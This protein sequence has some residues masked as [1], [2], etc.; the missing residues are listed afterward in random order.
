[1]R[2]I[3]LVAFWATA[4]CGDVVHKL[5][6][7]PVGTPHDSGTPDVPGDS[8]QSPHDATPVS[9][10]YVP[11]T[12]TSQTVLSYTLSGGAFQSFGCAPVD[13]TYWMSGSGMSAQVTFVDPQTNPS[14]RVWGMNTDDTASVQVNGTAYALDTTSASLAPKVVCGM[15][16][17]PDGMTF[18]A[19]DLTGTNTPGQGNYSYQDVTIVQTGVTS[20]KIASLTGAGWGLAGA[21]VCAPVVR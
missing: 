14:L 10:T 15:S 11:T 1:M 18:A 2:C 7:A 16:P 12:S 13:P 19:G 21:S 17:G 20:I 4:G 8:D 5:P 6:D 3:V 9:C